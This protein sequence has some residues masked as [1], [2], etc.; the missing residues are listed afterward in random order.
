MTRIS[1]KPIKNGN[2]NG[3]NGLVRPTTSPREGKTSQLGT[4]EQKAIIRAKA[5]L[6]SGNAVKAP[7][8]E[9]RKRQQAESIARRKAVQETIKAYESKGALTRTQLNDLI[10]VLRVEEQRISRRRE[11]ERLAKIAKKRKAEEELTKAQLET[12]GSEDKLKAFEDK[13]TSAKPRSKT[14][15][16]RRFNLIPEIK[17]RLEELD[18]MSLPRGE[19]LAFEHMSLEDKEA[20]IFNMLLRDKTLTEFLGGLSNPEF[21][22][23][24]IKDLIRRHLKI[25]S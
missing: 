21:G 6:D 8:P 17:L 16:R 9:E 24:I 4:D 25:E 12:A 14:T 7:T 20:Y 11:A 18:K 19:K 5:T 13:R 2:G 3:K 1:K 10:N 22:K 15:E 23:N